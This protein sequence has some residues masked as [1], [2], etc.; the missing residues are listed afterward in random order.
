MDSAL[1]E[2]SEI[3]ALLNEYMYLGFKDAGEDDTIR[4]IIQT[5][6]TNDAYKNFRSKDEFTILKANLDRIGDYTIGNQSWNLEDFNS[7][8]YACTF[9]DPD[10]GKIYVTYRGT[11]DGEWLD[12]GQGMTQVSTQ[13]QEEAARYFDYVIEHNGWNGSDNITV[14]GHSKGGNKSQYVTINSTYK[15]YIDQ[16]ISLDGQGFSPEAIAAFKEKYGEEAFREYLE[17]MYSINGENDYVNPLGVKVI[18]DDHT[19]YIKT[20]AKQDNFPAGHDLKYFFALYDEN[21]DPVFTDGK[22]QFGGEMNPETDRGLLSLTAEELSEALMK[23]PPDERNDAAMVIMQLMENSDGGKTGLNGETWT[24]ENII[25]FIKAGVPT[26]LLTLMTTPEGREFLVQYGGLFLKKA[27]DELGPLQFIGVVSVVVQLAPL[28]LLL[29]GGVYVVSVFLDTIISFVDSI[30]ELAENLKEYVKTICSEAKVLYESWLIGRK[31][32]NPA[33]SYTPGDLISANAG[34][35]RT[36][37]DQLSSIQNIIVRLDDRLNT[38]RKNQEWYEIID[39]IRIGAIDFL[40][41]GYDYDLNRC[42]VYLQNLANMLDNTERSLR[43]MA[44]QF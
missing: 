42:R 16:C 12:N 21:G 22:Q 9:K 29:A 40:Y 5:I 27:Y 41:V 44:A 3:C 39:K 17:K 37:A 36:I 6:E 10:T 1:R 35:I 26:V 15:D 2:K 31:I 34:Q 23:L 33:A 19:Y 30:K 14:T 24:A 13:Q 38:L 18:L 28:A 8:T 20:P 7:G 32:S 25:G 43:G 11:G 4:D